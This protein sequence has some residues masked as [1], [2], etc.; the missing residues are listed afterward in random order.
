MIRSRLAVPLAAAARWLTQV[1]LVTLA[2]LAVTERTSLA[3][4]ETGVLQARHKTYESPQNFAFELRVGPYHPRVDT[5]PELGAT[6]PYQA[7]FGDG[8]RWEIAAEFDWQAYRIPHVGTIGPGVSIGYTS[9]SAVAPLVTPVDG[10]R[11]SGET[12]SLLIIPTYLVAVLRIDVLSR[13]LHVPLVPYLKGGLG[14]AFWEASNS[15]G[16]SC[17]AP[18]NAAG[19]ATG[20]CVL[21]EGHT[22]GTQLAAGIALDL[23][24]LDRRTSQGFDNA[25]GVNHTF[26]FGELQ[27]Y[28]LTGILQ[29]HALYVGNH[30]WT[31]GLGFEF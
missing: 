30:N 12:T 13:D 23:N 31:V 9:S 4:D 7:E 8:M 21:G 11:L 25:T 19:K 24:F 17:Y 2:T 22:V 14:L 18:T 10:S 27:D 28:N 20:P 1:A 6:G 15:A 26:I 16:P 3:D 5:A 29:T